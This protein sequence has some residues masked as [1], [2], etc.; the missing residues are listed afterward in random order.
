M[1]RWLQWTAKAFIAVF[2]IG[3]VAY[4]GLWPALRWYYPLEYRQ[5]AERHAENHRIDPL[6]L[7]AVM[8]I[9][10]DFNPTAVSPKGARGLMQVMPETALWAAQ[11]MGLSSFEVD[12]LF[13]PEVNIAIG[14]WY[15]ATLR[16]QFD[17]DTVLALAAY[18]GGRTNVLRWLSEESWSGEV[19]TIDDIPFPETRGYVRKVL[20]TYAWYRRL[21]GDENP[22]AF[23]LPPL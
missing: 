23:L 2:L 15:L 10:S 5:A 17:G 12:Q 14:S 20:D 16:N 8:R 1:R 21:Y 9:E 3:T 7:V 19:E 18:N 6:L 22:L 4:V 11:Q 13:D